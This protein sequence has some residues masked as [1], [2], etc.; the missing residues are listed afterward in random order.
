MLFTATLH[1]YVHTDYEK[2]GNFLS[3]SE[4]IPCFVHALS[5][6]E[7]LKETLNEN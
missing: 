2:K 6:L 4:S 3:K 5:H 1:T 7:T